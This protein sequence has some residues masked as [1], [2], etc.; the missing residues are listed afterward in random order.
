MML[1]KGAKVVR[2]TA[3]YVVHHAV[4]LR[5][6]GGQRSLGWRFGPAKGV[7]DAEPFCNGH[8]TTNLDSSART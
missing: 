7:L 5:Q 3:P 8:S 4:G 1:W 6:F 2:R